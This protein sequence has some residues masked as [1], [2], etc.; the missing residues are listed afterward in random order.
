[1]L[2]ESLWRNAIEAGVGPDGVVVGLPI[3]DDRPRVGDVTEQMLIEAFVTEPAVETLDEPV[4]LRLSRCDI[5]P[6]HRPFLLP[7]QDRVRCH[8]AAVVTDEHQ[9]PAA[10][11]PDPVECA[12]EPFA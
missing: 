9:W 4:L 10:M 2:S 11:F 6:Q 7:G 5:V 12:A 1:M 8:L 3:L